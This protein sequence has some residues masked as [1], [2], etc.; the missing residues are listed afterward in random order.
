[1]PLRAIYLLEEAL[2]LQNDFTVVKDH[3]WLGD[4]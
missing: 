1:M 2:A 3:R 4:D